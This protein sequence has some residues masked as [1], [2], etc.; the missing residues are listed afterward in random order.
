MKQLTLS[1]RVAIEAGLCTGKTLK[2]IA[3]DIGKIQQQFLEKSKI[4]EATYVVRFTLIMTVNML[5]VVHE[6]I[7]AQISIAK[8]RV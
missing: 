2:K 7:F 1:D 8:R 4:T 3:E 6:N 5:D